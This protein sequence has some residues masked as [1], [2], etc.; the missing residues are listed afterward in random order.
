MLDAKQRASERE[1][2][3]KIRLPVFYI[4]KLLGIAMGMDHK[5]L[6]LHGLITLPMAFL[7]KLSKTS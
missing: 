4:T 2:G 7:R 3:K 5:K 6:G 1:L